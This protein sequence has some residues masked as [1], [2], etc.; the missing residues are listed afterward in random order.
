DLVTEPSLATLSGP[1]TGWPSSSIDALAM[2][3]PPASS[4]TLPVICTTVSFV[5]WGGPLVMVTVGATLSIWTVRDRD[6]VIVPPALVA[7]QVRLVDV[8]RV[9]VSQPVLVEGRI[10]PGSVTVQVMVTLVLFQPAWFGGG[11]CFNVM[12]GV[13]S[14][15]SSVAVPGS[16]E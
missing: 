5:Y 14:W 16:P 9:V 3:L 4:L 11:S 6:V 15:T 13:M 10:A 7:E 12:T 8:E 2:P 1:P